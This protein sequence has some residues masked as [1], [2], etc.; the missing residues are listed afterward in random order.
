MRSSC[1]ARIVVAGGLAVF[2]AAGCA[3]PIVYEGRFDYDDGW[4]QGEVLEV[5]TYD[6]LPRASL[7]DCRTIDEERTSSNDYAR[8]EYRGA[9]P[10]STRIV[11]LARDQTLKAGDLVYVKIDDCS[12]RLYLRAAADRS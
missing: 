9:R 4:R 6:G 5:G 8:V 11:P 3:W 2:L 1:I 10:Q 12:A 7:G